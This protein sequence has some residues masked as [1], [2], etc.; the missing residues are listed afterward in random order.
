MSEQSREK[1]LPIFEK[2][3]DDWVFPLAKHPKLMIQLSTL[4][5]VLDVE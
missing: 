4:F 5:M 1:K 3:H 2:E